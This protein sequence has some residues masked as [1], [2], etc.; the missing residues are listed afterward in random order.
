M[1][2][3]RQLALSIVAFVCLL[4][5]A[6]GG[7]GEAELTIG[8]RTGTPDVGNVTKAPDEDQEDGYG[9]TIEYSWEVH[10]DGLYRENVMR[11]D[12]SRSATV[13]FNLMPLYADSPHGVY[14]TEGKVEWRVDSLVVERNE[15][16]CRIL[17]MEGTTTQSWEL[18]E[19][20]FEFRLLTGPELYWQV[21]ENSQPRPG[22]YGIHFTAAP[23]TYRIGDLW[24]EE[25]DPRV[26]VDLSSTFCSD[27]GPGD[28][29]PNSPVFFGWRPVF[30]VSI[31][32]ERLQ[33]EMSREVSTYDVTG[34]ERISWDI[35]APE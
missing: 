14:D 35:I 12:E 17:E 26:S 33:G 30:F 9:N 6:C 8:S 3:N 34:I 11:V 10:G 7:D 32:D 31:N 20:E 22:E 2:A 18:G 23:L 27:A 13:R 25:D 21:D 1:F 24:Y 5:A 28:D 29:P 19:G 4:G 15:E 16:D